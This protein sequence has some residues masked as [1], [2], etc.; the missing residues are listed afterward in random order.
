MKDIQIKVSK[1]T[2]Y[3]EYTKSSLGCEAENLQGNLVFSFEDEFVNGQARLETNIQGETNWIQLTKEGEAYYCPIKST[4]TKQ[5]RV[6]M[7]LVIT[8]GT[9]EEEV[10]VFKSNEFYLYCE[11]SINAETE[12]PD[13]YPTWI[14]IANTK[15]NQMD[16]FDIDATKVGDTATVTIT[17]R[18]GT[19]KSV[20]IKDGETGPQGPEGP[21]GKAG[22]DGADGKDAKINGVNTLSIEAGDNISIDQTGST[23][24]ISATGGGGGGVDKYVVNFV[25][26]SDTITSDK[27]ITDIISAYN[28]GKLIEGTYTD[29]ESGV[30]AIINFLMAQD[31]GEFLLTQFNCFS[32]NGD[33]FFAFSIIG[34]NSGNEDDWQL[35]QRNVVTEDMLSGYE[36]TS[37]KTTSLNSSSTD[38]QYPSAKAVYDNAIDLVVD[39]SNLSVGS[40]ITDTATINKLKDKRV[41][42]YYNDTY[43]RFAKLYGS[44]YVYTVMNSYEGGEFITLNWTGSYFNFYQYGTA[45]WEIP[46][47]KVT[48]LSSSSTDTQYPSAKCVYNAINNAITNTLNGNY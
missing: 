23:M 45:P 48:S 18:D 41:I 5:G 34:I 2:R 43:F 10:P 14:E 4:M 1:E 36:Q 31:M 12:M 29:S 20:D 22:K 3:V 44:G 6:Y 15:L 37:H 25:N 16:N 30:T 27:S 26:E 42:V 21:A 13:E 32:D 40:N 19:E 39:I 28:S 46:S 35:L 33:D 11:K 38:T 9:D 8:E 17:Q 7:Q 47:N 24:T